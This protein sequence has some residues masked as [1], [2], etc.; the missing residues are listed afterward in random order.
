MLLNIVCETFCMWP[1]V[2]ADKSSIEERK[3]YEVS[4]RLVIEELACLS[5][6]CVVNHHHLCE[7]QIRTSTKPRER[8]ILYSI[9][10][11][12]SISVPRT[13]GS[14]VAFGLF[15]RRRKKVGTAKRMWTAS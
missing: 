11:V 15:R 13:L 12:Y 2:I 1:L 5:T 8:V 4:K 3:R 6:K 14:P 7:D 9:G 10:I